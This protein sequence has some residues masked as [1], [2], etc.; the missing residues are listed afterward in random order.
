M[1]RRVSAHL[2][3]I[4]H[5][6]ARGELRQAESLISQISYGDYYS[7]Y[8]AWDVLKQ[9]A[10]LADKFDLVTRAGNQAD[11]CARCIDD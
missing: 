6:C 8:L 4:V 10:V 9:A 1:P 3:S 11:S 5:F 2:Q 7:R